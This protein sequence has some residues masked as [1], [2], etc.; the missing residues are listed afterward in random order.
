MPI[1]ETL[2][3]ARDR[4]TAMNYG[5]YHEPA[6]LGADSRDGGLAEGSAERLPEPIPENMLETAFAA[7]SPIARPCREPCPLRGFS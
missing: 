6:A 5:Y 2:A 4:I 1:N 3:R 7:G